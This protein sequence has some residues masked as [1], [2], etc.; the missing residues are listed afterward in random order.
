LKVAAILTRNEIS[1]LNGIDV[2]YWLEDLSSLEEI[3]YAI[4]DYD[5][6]IITDYLLNKFSLHL[7][8]RYSKVSDYSENFH[9]KSN[10]KTNE[11][12]ENGNILFVASNDTHVKFFES[13]SLLLDNSRYMA[14]D[15]GEGA[16]VAFDENSK[17]YILFPLRYKLLKKFKKYSLKFLLMAF[18]NMFIDYL[19]FKFRLQNVFNRITSENISVIVFGND[20][21]RE[22]KIICNWAKKNNIKTVC[23]QEGPLDFG[24]ENRMMNAEYVFMQGAFFTNYIKRGN[25]IFTGNPRFPSY[26]PGEKQ[27]PRKIM[28]NCNFTYGNYEDERD[29]WIKDIVD[30]CRE[31]EVDYFISKHPRDKGDYS[32]Y[33]VIESNAFKI[34]NQIDDSKIVISR[35]STVIYEALLRGKQVIYYNPH[36]EDGRPFTDDKTG[37]LLIANNQSELKGLIKKVLNEDFDNK[38]AILEFLLL[39]C[40]PQDGKVNERVST[41]LSLMVKDLI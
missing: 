33:N 24:T 26:S 2:F 4:R 5:K 9:S 11:S 15:R 8:G 30:S 20:W 19:P 13:V 23:V 18:Y 16:N 35:F 22:E 17:P 3:L 39:H 7:D 10:K 1:N 31:L 28:V 25:M 29:T 12:K 37:G 14:I 40:G 41:A 6:V 27:S 21:G 34:S 36:N 38:E 32:Q